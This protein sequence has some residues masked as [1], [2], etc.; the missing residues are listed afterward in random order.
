MNDP[1]HPRDAG[2]TK[3]KPNLGLL[4]LTIGIEPQT[5][6]APPHKPVSRRVDQLR[7]YF[8][9]RHGIIRT[10]VELRLHDLSVENQ[11]VEVDRTRLEPA[12][13]TRSADRKLYVARKAHKRLR[14][15]LGAQRCRNV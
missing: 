2:A 11:K 3:R 6:L 15:E 4:R 12:R 8:R 5:A 1:P 14:I 7:G 10:S 13:S 9:K